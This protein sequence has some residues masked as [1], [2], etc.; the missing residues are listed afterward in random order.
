MSNGRIPLRATHL[1]R[2]LCFFYQRSVW[3][4]RKFICYCIL[5]C[6]FMP[7]TTLDSLHQRVTHIFS[8]DNVFELVPSEPSSDK[9]ETNVIISLTTVSTFYFSF[10]WLYYV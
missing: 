7:S 2:E 4:Q 3:F 1:F 10:T 8:F 5:A 9:E 6:I